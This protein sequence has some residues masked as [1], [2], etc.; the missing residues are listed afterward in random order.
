LDYE[1]TA[2]IVYKNGHFRFSF[3]PTYAFAQ[4]T[5]PYGTTFEQKKTDDIQKSSPYKPSVFYFSLGVS[6]K[7]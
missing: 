4:D 7:F 3:T 5:L 6:V 2:P 1:V